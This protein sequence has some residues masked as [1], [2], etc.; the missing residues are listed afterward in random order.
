MVIKK[1]FFIISNNCWFYRSCFGRLHN[2][3]VN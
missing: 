2:V 1:K 3:F